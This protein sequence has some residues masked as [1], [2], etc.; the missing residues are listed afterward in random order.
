M[1][2]RRHRG[3][4]GAWTVA[5][6]LALA[7]LAGCA[8]ETARLA[9]APADA[10]P[11]SV[12]VPLFAPAEALEQEWRRVPVWRQAEFALVADEGEVAIAASARGASAA[13]LTRAEI[14]TRTCPLVEWRWRVNA[15]AEPSDLAT[16][17]AEDVPA[18][19]LFAFGDP[20]SLLNP[21]DVPTLRYAWATET[22]PVGSVI[23][24]PYF[25]GILRTIVVRSGTEAMGRWVRERRDLAADYE[26][27]FGTPPEGPVEI[28]ALFTDSD[29][30]E[31][32]EAE[33]L[34]GPAVLLCTEAPEPPSIFDAG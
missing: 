27:A 7:A 5:P 33:A 32:R 29:H 19:L 9:E 34:Y 23:D 2:G 28:V 4:P 13:L 26:I 30:G 25:P 16:R 8:A 17:E 1:A 10:P 22:N 3:G 31:E 14:D 6:A 18:S 15:M 12:A 21:D 20:G 11:G 24:S